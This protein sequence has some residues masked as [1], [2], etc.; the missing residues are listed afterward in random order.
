M[1]KAIYDCLATN[2][3]TVTTWRQPYVATPATKKP[4]GVVVFAARTPVTRVG[5]FQDVT[6][7]LYFEAGD[8]IPLDAA[9]QEVKRLLHERRLMTDEGRPFEIQW[10]M[11]GRDFYDD[12]LQA[13]AKN[14]EFT[15]PGGVTW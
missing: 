13:I 4:F 6:V 5:T 7:W 15:I 14:I 3:Q 2:C 10:T 8:Y 1:R 11:D 12:A 9:I